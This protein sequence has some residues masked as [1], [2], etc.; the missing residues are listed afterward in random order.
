MKNRTEGNIVEK[1]IFFFDFW[2]GNYQVNISTLSP[3]EIL[4]I[5]ICF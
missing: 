4:E 5:D 1:V 2:G 3:F